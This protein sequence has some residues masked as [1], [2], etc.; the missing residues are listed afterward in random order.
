[1]RA[2]RLGV[3]AAGATLCTAMLIGT[4]RGHVDAGF[5]VGNA[6][7]TSTGNVF[8]V[9]HNQAYAGY[10]VALVAITLGV[11][12][13]GLRPDSRTGILL[14]AMPIIGLLTDPIVFAGSRVAVTVG[15]AAAWLDASA[16]DSRSSLP[17]RSCSSSTR[18]PRTIATFGTVIRARCRSRTSPGTT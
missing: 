6:L 13:W 4:I 12:V 14:T 2:V 8:V 9:P 7:S 18:A 15:L 17:S 10:L 3:W 16:T 1:M 11:L 5:Y